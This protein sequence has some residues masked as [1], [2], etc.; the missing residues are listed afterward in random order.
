MQASENTFPT[1]IRDRLS[2]Q[3]SIHGQGNR[4]KE[5]NRWNL[6]GRRKS[7]ACTHLGEKL[8]TEHQEGE[9]ENNDC[10]GHES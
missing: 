8:D 3:R 9:D 4:E 10:K 5:G 7:A 1:T 2:K 6:E